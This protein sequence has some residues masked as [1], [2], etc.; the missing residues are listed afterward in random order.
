M[1][2]GIIP[3]LASPGVMIP[4]QLGPMSLAEDVFRY[5]FTFTMSCTGIPSVMQTMS[6]IPASAASRMAS[7]A[8]AAGTKI[9]EV[10]AFTSFTASETVLKTGKFK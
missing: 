8:N 2:P 5:S 3:T 4:G 7:A 10:S 6:F 1:K 9:T